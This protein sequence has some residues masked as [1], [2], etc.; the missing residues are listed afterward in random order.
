[1]L[2]ITGKENC[3][4]CT[5]L[6]SAVAKLTTK[7]VKLDIMDPENNLMLEKVM[8]NGNRTPATLQF[9]EHSYIVSAQQPA[10]VAQV[11]AWLQ[12]VGFNA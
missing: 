9:R 10:K 4:L 11:Q 1:M 12:E 7:Y 3:G 2:F 6:E 8:A 5:S